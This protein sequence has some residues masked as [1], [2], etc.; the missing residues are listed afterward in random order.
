[1]T[2]TKTTYLELNN[3]LNIPLDNAIQLGK[4]K[5][6]VR[7]YFIEHVNRKTMFF[8]NT[9][10]K[11][12]YLLDEGYIEPEIINKHTK[13]FINKLFDMLYSKRY[14]FESFMGAY[15]FY[16]KYAMKTNDGELYLERYEDRVAFNA[17]TLGQGDEELTMRIAEAIIDHRYQPAT[18]THLS[19]GRV[20]RGE[21]VSCFLVDVADDLNSIGR[22]FNNV[23]QLSSI[24]G[25]VGINLSNL[26][27]LGDPIKKIENASNGLIP[28]MKIIEGILQYANQMGQRNG[29]GAVYLNIFHSEILNFLSTRKENA[30]ASK[31]IKMLSLGVVVPDKFYEL[32]EADKEMHLFSPYDVSKFY[33]VPF[34]HVDITREYDNMVN[35]PLI[36]STNIRA[37]DLDIEIG[38]L[39]QESG[40]PYI[41]NVDTANR[42][43]P[44]A[45]KITMSNLC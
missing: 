11:I 29:A 36:R 44:I 38:K 17:L 31:Q 10:E 43:N 35:N 18:P 2:E 19:A 21:Y 1:M 30:E 27:G 40:Y 34:S 8:H 25:G 33:G 24:G 7:A 16:N 13:A 45:G 14:R 39:Q 22:L 3:Q 37:R 42:A 5:E 26:R 15:S 23:A 20:N 41:L 9:D 12:R 6:A 28:V 4:D 32:L